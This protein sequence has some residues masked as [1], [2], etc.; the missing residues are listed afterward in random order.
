VVTTAPRHARLHLD[1]DL[2]N[3]VRA[4]RWLAEQLEQ[5]DGLPPGTAEEAGVALSEVVTNVFRH[6]GSPATVTLEVQVG[7]L[8][9]EV[10]DAE[11]E[12]RPVLRPVD[13]AR[14]GGNGIRILEAFSTAW[15]C[16]DAEAGGKIVWFTLE[17]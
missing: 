14:A 3:V 7:R 12:R 1:R 17:W 15:G 9:V 6:T 2:S 11:A 10:H 8:E 4:R 16:R 13:P 5:I